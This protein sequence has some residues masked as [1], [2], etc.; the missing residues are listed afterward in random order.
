MGS[1][2]P[3]VADEQERNLHSDL[4]GCDPIRSREVQMPHWPLDVRLYP[5]LLSSPPVPNFRMVVFICIIPT[6][7]TFTDE[8]MEALTPSQSPVGLGQEWVGTFQLAMLCCLNRVGRLASRLRLRMFNIRA[9]TRKH[10][11]L[12]TEPRENLGPLQRNLTTTLS[13]IFIFSPIFMKG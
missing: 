13:S 12:R 9:Q 5:P 1:A 6:S 7:L 11:A 2:G 3:T 10:A 8:E 4:Y